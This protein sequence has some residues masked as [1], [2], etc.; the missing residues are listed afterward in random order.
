MMRIDVLGIAQD[1]GCPQV[2]CSCIHC[3][4]ARHDPTQRRL[5]ACLGITSADGGRFLLDAT[6]ALPEQLDR[7]QEMTKSPQYLPDATLL[8][9]AHIGHYTG[10]MYL[11]KEALNSHKHPVYVTPQM[12]SFLQANAPWRDLV[13]NENIELHY[14]EYYTPAHLTQSLKVTAIP[15]SHRNEYA[16]TVGFLITENNRKLF[17]LPDLDRLG[18]FVPTLNAMLAQCQFVFFDATF[19]NHEELPALSGRDISNIP[20]PT[21]EQ[22]L[23]FIEQ[24]KIR[25]G[26]CQLNLIH[27]NHSNR[28]I[29]HDAERDVHLLKAHVTQPH[30]TFYL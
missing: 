19:Y 4:K 14:L 10:L 12:A 29:Q 13:T 21:V 9:H 7:W 27:F 28:L 3:T 26:D 18:S 20:H 17:Y 5:P 24:G 23:T 30:E 11:G 15:V 16:D 2:G 25:L 8:T 1:A 6:P 22:I